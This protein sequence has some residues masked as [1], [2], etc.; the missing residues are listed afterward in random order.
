[1]NGFYDA[2]CTILIFPLLVYLGASGKTTDKGTAKICK[3]L[4]DISYPVY[5]IHYPFMYLFYA[6]LWS[7]EPHITFSQSWP[8]ALC[9]FVG[10]IV[11]A[12]LC[13]K[14]YDEPVRKWL[15]K[16]FLTKK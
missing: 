16:K 7:K 5:I 14:L 8:V 6:W 3:F 1:M 4:G 15:S 2:V 12:Y 9:F 10:S 11:L 13:L